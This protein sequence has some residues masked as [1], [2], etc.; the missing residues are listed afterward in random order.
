MLADPLLAAYRDEAARRAEGASSD[1]YRARWQGCTRH[2]GQQVA[3]SFRRRLASGELAA[4]GIEA[5]PPYRRVE[6][7]ASWWP[8]CESIVG[9]SAMFRGGVVLRD[10][11]VSGRAAPRKGETSSAAAAGSK[12]PATIAGRT[13]VPLSEAR[14]RDHLRSIAAT[15]PST[16]KALSKVQA[17]FPGY[18]VTRQRVRDACNELGIEGHPGRR[19]KSRQEIPP[20][21]DA[22]PLAELDGGK[23][24]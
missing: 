16:D 20:K 10:V 15:I 2:F 23:N 6:I 21:S 11:M 5:S 12:P 7:G 19:A 14:L 18:H 24:L 22:A 3:A 1:H 17:A 4:T 8:H 9:D 13:H